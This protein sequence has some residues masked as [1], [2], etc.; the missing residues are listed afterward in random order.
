MCRLYDSC[1]CL[2]VMMPRHGTHAGLGLDSTHW[3]H[4]DFLTVQESERNREFAFDASFSDASGMAPY[5][6]GDDL[7]PGSPLPTF[8]ARPASPSGFGE[9]HLR[10]LDCT[11][12][13]SPPKASKRV[14]D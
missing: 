1:A 4:N 10:A 9:T 3:G 13:A 8:E 12:S 5:T 2:V 7:R 6:I 11:Q 14:H